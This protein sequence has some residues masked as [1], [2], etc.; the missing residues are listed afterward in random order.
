M[1]GIEMEILILAVIAIGVMT[2]N[3]TVIAPTLRKLGL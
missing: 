2:V 3:H 1:K